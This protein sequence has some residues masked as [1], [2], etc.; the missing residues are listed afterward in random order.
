MPK[1]HFP[2]RPWRASYGGIPLKNL[3]YL[4][5]EKGMVTAFARQKSAS[6]LP[7]LNF[8]ASF[9]LR[10]LIVFPTTHC[11]FRGRTPLSLHHLGA[12]GKLATGFA[13]LPEPHSTKTIKVR[14]HPCT[15]PLP[16]ACLGRAP[17]PRGRARPA[18][19]VYLT[20]DVLEFKLT[21][22]KEEILWLRLQSG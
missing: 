7:R 5:S 6:A 17:R 21:I 15:A 22:L 13:Q 1:G 10:T 18:L 14:R 4:P 8:L 9:P 2:P 12:G 20:K 3:D 16:H 11:S 19:L